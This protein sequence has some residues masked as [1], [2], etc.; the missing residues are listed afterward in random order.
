MT[1]TSPPSHEARCQCGALTATVPADAAPMTVLCH[2]SD[3]QRRTGSPFGTIA[4][5]PRESVSLTGETRSYS[6]GTATGGTIT[7]AFCP[8]CGST[9]YV[10]MSRKPEIAGIPVGAF[11]DPAFP[12]A[13]RSVW[14]QDRHGWVTLPDNMVAFERGLDGK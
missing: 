6:R 5:Y 11:A 2:C 3:C 1:D 9:L 10:T 7:N 4:Y 13:A 12:P 8:Q 14:G